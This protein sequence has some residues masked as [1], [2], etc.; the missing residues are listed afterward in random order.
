MGSWLVGTM[1][2]GM[3]TDGMMTRFL[4]GMADI[5]L[6]HASP[7]LPS[8][9]TKLTPQPLTPLENRT[10]LPPPNPPREKIPPN[11]LFLLYTRL[12]GLVSLPWTAAGGTG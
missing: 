6:V 11:P 12:S 4:E 3:M 9:T 2:D 7:R 1:T 10:H 8:L 5:S